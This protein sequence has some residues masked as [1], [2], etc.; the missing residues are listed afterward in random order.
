MPRALTEIAAPDDGVLDDI[1]TPEA[2]ARL[3]GRKGQEGLRRLGPQAPDPISSNAC[4]RTDCG[5]A[6]Q[7]VTGVWGLRPQPPE[8]PIL[9][10]VDDL[11]SEIAPVASLS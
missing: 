8:A 1:D 11:R 9:S 4:L 5:H 10:D 6:R 2:L 3:R 7:P